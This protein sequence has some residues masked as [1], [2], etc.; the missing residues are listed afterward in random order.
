MI[1]LQEL[2]CFHTALGIFEAIAM[3]KQYSQHKKKNLVKV[4]FRALNNL[5]ETDF[6]ALK[7]KKSS[8]QDCAIEI[9]RIYQM[10]GQ[11]SLCWPL[12]VTSL[13]PCHAHIVSIDIQYAIDQ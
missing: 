3:S 7:T 4:K 5:G 2:M 1:I 12:I 11:L 9:S 10:N 13:P 6:K 8:F